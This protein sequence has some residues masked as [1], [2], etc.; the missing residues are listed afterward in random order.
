MFRKNS[1][2]AI[3]VAASILLFSPTA[4]ATVVPFDFETTSGPNPYSVIGSLTIANTLNVLNGFDILA[5]TGNVFGLGGAAITGL[6]SNPNQPQPTNNGQY[7][8]DNVGF[9]G[10]PHLDNAG[11]LFT[12]GSYTYNI[13]TVASNDSFTYYLS[14]TNPNGIFDPGQPGTLFADDN[15]SAVPEL[16]TWAMMLLGFAGLGF[17]AHRK[18][19]LGLAYA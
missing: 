6:V 10:M 3:I 4:K 8:Y 2:A 5:I 11:V 17:L 13:Y 9:P 18:K 1:W 19:R 14:S 16:S 7:I 15:V 12:A